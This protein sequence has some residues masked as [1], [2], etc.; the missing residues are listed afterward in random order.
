MS[1]QAMRRDDPRPFDTLPS[2]LVGVH[3]FI[4]GSLRGRSHDTVM[5]LLLADVLSVSAMVASGMTCA[6]RA[7]GDSGFLS[8]SRSGHTCDAFNRR[9]VSIFESSGSCQAGVTLNALAFDRVR[10]GNK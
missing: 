4:G 1:V 5:E 7:C 9:C 3:G 10:D 2:D 6:E 8:G